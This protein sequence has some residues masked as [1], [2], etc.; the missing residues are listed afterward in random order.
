VKRA[1]VDSTTK[2]VI[3]RKEEGL[4]VVLRKQVEA[5]E[6]TNLLECVHLIHSALPEINLDDVDISTNFLGHNLKAPVMIDSM[7]GGAPM[8]ERVNGTLAAVAE[9]VGLGMGVG[10]QRAGLLSAEMARTYSIARKNAPHAFLFANIGGAQLAKGL[11]L[12]DAEKLVEMVGADAFAVHLNPLQ[13]L[14]QPEGEPLFK[15]VLSKIESLAHNLS[16]PVI[17]KEVGAGISK[18]VAMKLELAGVKALNVSGSGGTS[19][20]AVEKYRAEAREMTRKASLGELFWDWGIPTAAALIEARKAVRIPL[21]GSGGIRN[22]LEIAKC[23]SIG[24]DVCS[25]A[26]PML[27]NAVAGK[28]VLEEFVS[29]LITELRAT[30]FVTGSKDLHA[31]KKVRKVITQPL[32]SW[33]QP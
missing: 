20:A 8:A 9:E 5:K 6:N 10:S 33:I 3:K 27:K 26:S 4:N 31:L 21:V 24:A 28:D 29:Q 25:M 12:E 7:T 17:V 13:E 2:E 30:M 11:S 19:W 16:V 14:V 15:G 22:G 32:S 1:S 23:L 18:E